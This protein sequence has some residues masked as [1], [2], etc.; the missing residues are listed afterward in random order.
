MARFAEKRPGSLLRDKFIFRLME[1]FVVSACTNLCPVLG[2]GFCLV[3]G[4][5]AGSI[6][7]NLLEGISAVRTYNA[8]RMYSI[9]TGFVL[10]SCYHLDSRYGLAGMFGVCVAE[11]WRPRF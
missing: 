2:T 11:F 6:C 9:A 7:D 1:P 10:C 3:A 4:W 8:I 5:V